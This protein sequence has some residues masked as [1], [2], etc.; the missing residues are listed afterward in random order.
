VPRTNNENL[1]AHV[2]VPRLADFGTLWAK[3]LLAE[4][5]SAMPA[6][7]LA[8]VATRHFACATSRSLRDLQRTTGTHEVDV[9]PRTLAE[10]KEFQIAN[11]TSEKT[12]ISSA[13]G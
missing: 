2:G 8:R 10:Y 6:A 5:A 9:L 1:L 12:G 3:R 13:Y 7:N 11:C 4:Q